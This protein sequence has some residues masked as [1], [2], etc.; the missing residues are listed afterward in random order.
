MLAWSAA[1]VVY[2]VLRLITLKRHRGWE[3]EFDDWLFILVVVFVAIRIF[4]RFFFH[5]GLIFQLALVFAGFAAGIGI[6]V[7]TKALITQ[8]AGED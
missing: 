2:L 5:G 8:I 4:A 7:R 3:K 1:I 6:L